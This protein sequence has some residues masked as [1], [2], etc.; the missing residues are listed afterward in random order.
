MELCFNCGSEIR[1]LNGYRVN[2]NTYCVTC[3]N[4]YFKE[5]KIHGLFNVKTGIAHESS[6]NTQDDTTE[7]YI[8]PLSGTDDRDL[9][10][11]E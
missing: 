7:P 2:G 11:G 10:G 4:E 3:Y 5:S 8:E 1:Y 6:I 9:F